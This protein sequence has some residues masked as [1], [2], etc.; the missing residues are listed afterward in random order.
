VLG[1]IVEHKR[2]EVA[3]RKARLSLAELLDRV[4][5]SSRRLD[6]ALA[7]D[8]VALILESKRMSP[9]HGPLREPYDPAAIAK[10]YAPF[11][12]AISV[13]TDEQFFGGSLD[14]LRAARAVADVP[15]L[16]KDFVIDPYQVVEARCHGADAVLL[17]LSV[18]DDET[19]AE[20]FAA[21]R[22]H[23][24]DAVVEVHDADE[25]D[26]ALELDASIIGINNRDLKT[27]TVD[28][29]ATEQLAAAVPNE[30]LVIGES[31]IGTYAD[32]RRLGPRVNALLTGSRFCD[33]SACAWPHQGVRSDAPRGRSRRLGGGRCLRR[34][35][36]RRRVA[37]VRERGTSG[38]DP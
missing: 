9:S 33:P 38:D 37:A 20:C 14:D 24:M 8:A 15:L 4:A 13:L 36:L 30:K 10:S 6:A 34:S 21:A 28:L 22:T 32:V 11:A 29:T 35:H 18:L 12:A 25:L 5:P 1:A 2:R 16:C 23:G 17:M 7:G 19:C 3:A 31:G 27:L 26:R